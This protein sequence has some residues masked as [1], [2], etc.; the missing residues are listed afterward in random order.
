MIR[1]FSFKHRAYVI[2]LRDAVIIFIAFTVYFEV[3]L[4]YRDT[5]FTADWLDIL[6]YALGLALFIRWMNQ[7][8]IAHPSP[9]P[10]A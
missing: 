8:P 9:S 5:R 1:T 3:L 6:C 4:P 7:P 2:H 10:T